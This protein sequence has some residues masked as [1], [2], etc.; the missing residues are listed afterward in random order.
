MAAE[1]K[2]V[3]YT[4]IDVD[5][6]AASDDAVKTAFLLDYEKLWPVFGYSRKDKA[7]SALTRGSEGTSMTSAPARGLLFLASHNPP[8][9]IEIG[10]KSGVRMDA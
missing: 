7:V 2:E 10:R 6:I 8:C 1:D 4:E 5:A 9:Q 3:P